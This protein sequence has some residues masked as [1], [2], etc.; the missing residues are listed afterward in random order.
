MGN[1][2]AVERAFHSALAR[3]RAG[4]LAA[5]EQLYR[6]LLASDPHHADSLHLLGVLVSQNKQLGGAAGL[7]RRAIALN[8]QA[9]L[10]HSNLGNILKD[11]GLQDE[12]R[13]A[14]GTAILLAP[15]FADARNN[16]GTVLKGQGRMAAAVVAFK[17]AAV[18][19]PEF[20]EAYSNLGAALREMVE[21]ALALTAHKRA[22]LLGP[23]LPEAQSN[24]GNAL[25]AHGRP[26]I[27]D[28]CHRAAVALK[29]DYAEA[30]SNLGNARTDQGQL[31]DAAIAYDFAIRINPDYAEAYYNLANVLK[32]MGRIAEAVAAYKTSIRLRPDYAEAHSNL[33]MSVHYQE[34]IDGWEIL[35]AAR[36]FAAR[37]EKVPPVFGNVATISR[38]LRI[39]YVSGDFRRHPVGFFLSDVLAN[40]DRLAVEVF[41]YTNNTVADDMTSRLRG[42][43]D[44]WR[45]L[46]GV[47]D[48]QALEQV[49][50][51]R[52]DILVD[53]SGHTAHG[54]L[55]LFAGK[56]APVQVSWLGFWGTTGLSAMDYILSDEVT[57][58]FGEEPFYIERVFR[59][60]GSRFCYKPP[61][62]APSPAAE[63]PLRRLNHVTFG[64]FNNLT[65]VGPE[66][67]R[68]WADVMQAVPGSRLLLKWKSM[69]DGSVRRRLSDDFAA[70]GVEPDRLELRCAS[71]HAA[72]LG[73]YA[74]I[75]IA[76][77]PFPFSGGLTSC[78]ALWMGVP[79]VTW[80]G[81]RAPSRQTFG[82]LQVLGL[83]KWAAASAKDYIAIAVALASDAGHLADLRQS[84]RRRMAASAL[85]DG[86][87]F[88]RRLEGA[89]RQM[90]RQWCD[91]QLEMDRQGG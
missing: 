2:G 76:L 87:A 23:D 38:R 35:A 41:C 66:V 28:A 26:T 1:S 16:L 14:Y 75:D 13:A 82:F 42:A 78:E 80:P 43:A 33:L 74:D 89:Y 79:V 40:H 67:V 84:L 53:L 73:E 29:P 6:R 20:S 90:W 45:S 51:D 32:D 86:P 48:Q 47:S 68:L 24:L 59:L 70:A 88:T 9:A 65:K 36:Q 21:V 71:P 10:Y 81:E 30:Y 31:H 12:A 8:S 83:T 50:A 54:C 22:I 64:S 11:L 25:I 7:I 61:D 37:F 18:L 58:P 60:A 69:A 62:Y 55:P 57:I 63:P 19:R 17:I 72:M 4:H 15:D 56:P 85:C 3:H 44:H 52:I 49:M 5:A 39:G 91:G 46:V 27:A 34:G 77:D